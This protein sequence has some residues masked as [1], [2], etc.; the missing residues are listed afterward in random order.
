KRHR[1]QS[2]TTTPHYYYYSSSLFLLLH[3]TTTLLLQPVANNAA[4][5]TWNNGPEDNFFCGHA[6]DDPNCATRQNCRS[7]RDSECEGHE[8]HGI[9][10]FANTNCDTKFGG[11]AA[12]VPGLVGY[13]VDKGERPTASPSDLDFD[14]LVG[15]GLFVPTRSP[16]TPGDPTHIP[17][18]FPIGAPPDFV[19]SSDDPTDHMYCGVGIDDA[20]FRCATHC[21]NANECPLGEICYYRT[22]C[23]HRTHAPTPPPT[24]G[25][26]LAPTTG[27]PTVSPAPTEKPTVSWPPTE[28]PTMP[29]PSASPIVKPTQR[30][31]HAPLTAIQSGFFC[32][33]SWTDTV[34]K[35]KKRCPSG[36]DPECPGAETC[37]A[38]TGC[39]TEKGYGSDPSKWIAGYDEWGNSIAELVNQM[40]ESEAM[41][42]TKN[43][44]G[45]TN[46][47]NN[48]GDDE[49]EPLCR[50][51]KVTITADNWPQEITWNII[52]TE[53]GNAIITG[54]NDDLIPNE[55]IATSICLP[56]WACYKFQIN[57]A[58]GDGLCCEHGNGMYSLEW[59][60]TVV[61]NG[62]AFYDE[63]SVEFGCK[64][65]TE[66]PTRTPTGKPT[67]TP[68]GKPVPNKPNGSSNNN[69]SGQSSSAAT[70][71]SAS[72]NSQYRCVAN[73][74]AEAG[75]AVSEKFCDRFIDCYNPYIAMGD[76]WY[77]A[78]NES[79]IEADACGGGAVAGVA[80]APEVEEEAAEPQPMDETEKTTVSNKRPTPSSS[81]SNPVAAVDISRPTKQPTPK[82]TKQPTDVPS[83]IPTIA[84]VLPPT[85]Q[86]TI[87]PTSASPTNS[88]T[89]IPT[90]SPTMGPCGGDR[91]P[92]MSHC[93]SR[94]G[95]CGPG[96]AY[97][98][99]T[100]IWTSECL[101]QPTVEPTPEPTPSPTIKPTASG[102]ILGDVFGSPS[103]SN[104]SANVALAT[105]PNPTTINNP[106]PADPVVAFQKPSG[107]SKNKPTGGK[108]GGGKVSTGKESG[109]ANSASKPTTNGAKIPVFETRPPTDRPTNPPSHHPTAKPSSSPMAKTTASGK[110]VELGTSFTVISAPTHRPITPVVVEGGQHVDYVDLSTDSADVIVVTNAPTTPRPTPNPTKDSKAKST[111]VTTP[112]IATNFEPESEYSCT[113]TPCPEEL[114]CR[115]RYGSCGPGYIY[116]NVY[117]TWKKSCPPMAPRPTKPPTTRPTKKPTASKEFVIV[118][119]KPSVP[120]LDAPSV[121]SLPTLPKPT[122]PTIR[123]VNNNLANFH[124]QT[125]LAHSAAGQSSAYGHGSTDEDL[126]DTSDGDGYG[127][128]EEAE[129][130]DDVAK[131]FAR[132]TEDNDE[133]NDDDEEEEKEQEVTPKT[134]SYTGMEEWI[135][136]TDHWR[137]RSGSGWSKAK[138]PGVYSGGARSL[139]DVAEGSIRRER[140]DCAF[141]QEDSEM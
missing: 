36:E 22:S 109:T 116:C 21:P 73:P 115:S 105:V 99:E 16:H 5:V 56:S 98:T 24:R 137:P 48:G 45:N 76:N 61:T 44:S 65:E 89:E 130:D 28:S 50:F 124:S 74:L 63:E 37:F 57:D 127:D 83:N 31:T 4:V 103:G 93:R 117:S 123:D 64:K 112:T 131:I 129:Y 29:R 49:D 43:N 27:T 119:S 68:T 104:N 128:D 92:E 66:V 41:E 135:E 25:P 122:L 102:E 32:G 55:P 38:Y 133:E 12:Y 59:D 118:T 53:T 90:L 47:Q 139:I 8:S 110:L 35:C 52:D 95:F 113:G 18:E 34:T 17:T 26:T 94:Y 87:N 132:D 97:C 72:S 71:N 6:W 51:T 101:T 70:Q 114:W 125:S 86:P 82:P 19:G 136:Y 78:D 69:Q 14:S 39:T 40:K 30:P 88:P 100:A 23:D 1:R 79:C 96:E 9:Q 134:P 108:G 84:P 10:C 46:S 11:S 13:K 3:T 85:A 107:G 60:G 2:S 80:T 121:A 33:T 67:R 141:Y 62:A 111:H 126:F 77:C 140:D 120:A 91:C 54:D 106:A 81:D 15:G 42:A 7:G 58:G 75:Y 138:Q 20:S